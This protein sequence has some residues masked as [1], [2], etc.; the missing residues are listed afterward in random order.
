MYNTNN[1]LCPASHQDS[2]SSEPLASPQ[3]LWKV[4]ALSCKKLGIPAKR[5][6]RRFFELPTFDQHI[7][8]RL[9]TDE[10]IDRSSRL[11][12]PLVLNRQSLDNLFTA[13]EQDGAEMVL[14]LRSIR[15]KARA[16]LQQG[17]GDILV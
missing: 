1:N 14:L 3:L 2:D 4:L 13:I 11:E 9:W 16:G 10:F 5:F 12:Y 15:A 17:E 7:L 8:C 6:K